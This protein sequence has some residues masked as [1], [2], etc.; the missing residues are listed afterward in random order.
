MFRSY[1]KTSWRSIKK[2]YAY[3]IINMINLGLAMGCSVVAYL[4]Y[5]FYFQFD[6]QHVHHEEIYRVN[7]HRIIEGTEEVYG[8]VPISLAPAIISNLPLGTKEAVRFDTRREVF[9]YG[10]KVIRQRSAYVDENFFDVFTYDLL[11]GDLSVIDDPNAIIIT[12]ATA[13]AI[14]EK[15]NAIGERLTLVQPSGEELVFR[16]GAVLADLPLNMSLRFSILFNYD[17]H[18]QLHDVPQ[19]D[20]KY[21]T[22]AVFVQ[23]DPSQKD[24]IAKVINQF[25]SIQ[26]EARPDWKVA[27]FGLQNITDSGKTAWNTKAFGLKLNTHPSQVVG[28]NILGILLLLVA[29]FNFINT[30]L[31]SLR[32]RLKE[33]GIRKVMG[34]R[35]RQLAQQFLIEN[36][37]LSFAA[38]IVA[39]AV[40]SLLVPAYSSMWGWMNLE[41]DFSNS[42]LLTFMIGLLLTTSLAGVYPALHVS[43]YNTVSILRDK[44]KLAGPGP[45]SKTLLSLQFTLSVMA[46]ISGVGFYQNSIFQEEFS[47]GFDMDNMIAVRVNNYQEFDLY[48]NELSSIPEITNIARSAHHIARGKDRRTVEYQSK[49]FETAFFDVGPQYGQTAG[50]NILEGRDFNS[51]LEKSDINSSVLVNE[52]FVKKFNLN[53]PLGAMVTVSDSLH[54][55]VIGVIEDVYE[56]GTFYPIEP[57]VFRLSDDSNIRWLLVRANNRDLPKINQHMEATWANL[58]PNS[59]YEAFFQD[60]ISGV[61]MEAN[62]NAIKIFSFGS[63]LAVFFAAIGLF[64]IVSL[65][66]DNK[67]KEMGIRKTLGHP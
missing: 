55:R 44:I 41:F 19:H 45:F 43:S 13:M 67:T 63:V 25:V 50:F 26:N 4:N 6:T 8:A 53:S 47:L 40:A 65:T 33:I 17:K 18:L 48:R 54:F 28:I 32:K 37:L 20:W 27:S 52:N 2:N 22:T 10:D 1:L 16:V 21:N 66:I 59:I 56:M 58:F 64:A 7:S 36:L 35:K 31:A 5:E 39:S 15:S 12:E 3:S 51:E 38:L 29:C 62:Q 23:I 9:K 11:H 30:S 24:D 42:T 61:T 34:A 60:D 14:F 57:M 46:V 49:E